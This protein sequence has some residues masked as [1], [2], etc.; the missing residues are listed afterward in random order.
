[1]AFKEWYK[2][3]ECQVCRVLRR[4]VSES[5]AAKILCRI[6]VVGFVSGSQLSHECKVSATTNFLR[7]NNGPVK[8]EIF[9]ITFDYNYL[10][11]V[12]TRRGLGTSPVL[13]G[14]GPCR[15]VAQ[16]IHRGIRSS[17]RIFNSSWLMSRDGL[18]THD[19]D[20]EIGVVCCYIF[21]T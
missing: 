5:E 2:A 8:P 1:M 19:V 14:A 15:T 18:G 4:A 7:R 11:E 21:I 9:R 13:P 6:K 20:R 10:N 16:I 3:V 17:I 12:Q